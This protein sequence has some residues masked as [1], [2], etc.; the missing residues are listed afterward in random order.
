MTINPQERLREIASI[1]D[2]EIDTKDIPELDANFWENAMLRFKGKPI[3]ELTS[4][5]KEEFIEYRDRIIARSLELNQET[6]LVNED[7]TAW[8]KTQGTDYHARINAVL[9]DYVEAHR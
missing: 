6:I 8:F 7:I 1:P 5:E 4:Q 3:H 9:R 2:E